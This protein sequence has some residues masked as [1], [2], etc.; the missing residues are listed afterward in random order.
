[1]IDAIK[2]KMLNALETINFKDFKE[3]FHNAFSRE[4]GDFDTNRLFALMG[5][6]IVFSL[7]SYI[8][9]ISFFLQFCSIALAG[10]ILVDPLSKDFNRFKNNELTNQQK[11]NLGVQYFSYY[12][13]WKVP[14]M[15]LSFTPYLA[16]VAVV[17]SVVTE[18]NPLEEV[19][20]MFKSNFSENPQMTT[21]NSNTF[22]NSE[23]STLSPSDELVRSSLS[24]N[25]AVIED[26]ES[27]RC[28][29]IK[30]F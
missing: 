5:V 21:S 18:K 23:H 2:S 1:M 3:Y 11:F 16:V 27:K 12:L 24:D 25:K 6:S 26:S 20:E 9:L 8:P 29:G 17:Y 7:A 13:C 30:H 28:E 15:F 19:Y 14:A 10:L 22:S 4:N